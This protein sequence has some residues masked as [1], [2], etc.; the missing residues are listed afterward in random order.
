MGAERSAGGG[1]AEEGPNTLRNYKEIKNIGNTGFEL[2]SFQQRRR[3]ESPYISKNASCQD[4]K[5]LAG[6]SQAFPDQILV[7]SLIRSPMA[8]N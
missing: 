5:E 6:N 7:T 2:K 1:G 8:T 4:V 3:R